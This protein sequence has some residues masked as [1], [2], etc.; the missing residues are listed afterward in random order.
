MRRWFNLCGAA[1]KKAVREGLVHTH[2]RGGVLWR[3][4]RLPTEALRGGNLKW[5]VPQNPPPLPVFPLI[6]M[7]NQSRHYKD[8]E[9]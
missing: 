2:F 1:R 3:L 5:G 9:V 8:D 6:L 4:F 7:K